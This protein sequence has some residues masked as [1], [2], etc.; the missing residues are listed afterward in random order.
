MARFPLCFS[1]AATLAA[2]GSTGIVGVAAQ[3]SSQKMIVESSA[4]KEGQPLPRDYAG[5]GRNVSPPLT[6]R[7]VPAGTKEFAVLSEDPDAGNPPPNVHWVLYRIPPAVQGLPEDVP[8]AV[9]LSSP[10]QLAGAM[11]GIGA[12][13]SG[14][15]GYRG[16][17][18]P[19]GV[20]HHYRFVVYA[21]DAVLDLKPN[22]DRAGLLQAIQ[23]HIIGEGDIT[24]T[25]QRQTP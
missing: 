12:R 16:P 21:L 18:P 1:L 14:D 11:Q 2:L 8:P 9:T 24:A 15:P 17:S 7:N 5:E 4:F 6:W 22:L 10:T 19:A 23:G 3:G 13:R 25:Y 20:T